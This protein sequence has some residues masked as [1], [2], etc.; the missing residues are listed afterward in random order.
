M[1]TEQKTPADAGPHSSEGLGAGSEAKKPTAFLDWGLR[2]ECPKC[3]LVNDLSNSLHDGEHSIARYIF[4][5]AWD[6]LRDWE[7]TCEG[8]EHE[9]KIERVEY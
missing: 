9:F 4:S 5:N 7:V 8:C 3:N 1:T 2:V 6:K